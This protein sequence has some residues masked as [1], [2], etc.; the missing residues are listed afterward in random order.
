VG[1]ERLYL[2]KTLHLT[3]AQVKVKIVFKIY[4]KLRMIFF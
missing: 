4:I 1:N 2:A 3:E